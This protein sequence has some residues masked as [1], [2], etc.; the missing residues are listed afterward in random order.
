MYQLQ[1]SPAGP[2]VI[3]G[4][5][6]SGSAMPADTN[7]NLMYSLPI[8]ALKKWDRLRVTYGISHTNS[9]NNKTIGIE[10]NAT[11]IAS[12]VT[13]AVAGDRR[14]VEIINKGATNSQTGDIGTTAAVE[15][16][17]GVTLNI[18]GTKATGAE[19]L[20]LTDVLVELIQLSPRTMV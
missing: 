16:K 8:K 18:Y 9:A 3:G 10:L 17:D 14:T 15:T 6:V 1:D 19:S 7:K 13:S 5:N 4:L 20:I 2:T 12:K 11:A